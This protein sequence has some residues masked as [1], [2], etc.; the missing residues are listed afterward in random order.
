MCIIVCHCTE[1]WIWF[2]PHISG[3]FCIVQGVLFGRWMTAQCG[4]LKMVF[5]FVM[6]FTRLAKEFFIFHLVVIQASLS[7]I[8]QCSQYHDVR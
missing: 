1:E 3:R 8:I 5:K 7:H 6:W 4:V 2:Y